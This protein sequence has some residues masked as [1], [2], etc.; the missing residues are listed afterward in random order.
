MIHK[1]NKDCGKIHALQTVIVRPHPGSCTAALLNAQGL[2]FPAI[3]GRSGRSVFKREGDG[4]TPLGSMKI[5]CGFYRADRVRLPP[6]RLR[7]IPIRADT[8]WCDAPGAAS[9]NQPVRLPFNASHEKM[10]RKDRLYDICLVLD[11][12]ITQRRRNIGSAIFWHLT[13]P[14]GRPTEGCIAIDP[15]A[16]RR[17]LPLL[18][19]QTIV[20]VI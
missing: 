13:D 15:G 2:V 12:N 3:I 4:A 9:Y 20:R 7:M 1:I 6:T 19:R 8:G 5:I 11:W 16:M 14:G 10:M 18:S 17:L